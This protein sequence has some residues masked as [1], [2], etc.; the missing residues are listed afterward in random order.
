[1]QF[2]F[3][4]AAPRVSDSVL[5][6]IDTQVELSFNL[7]QRYLNGRHLVENSLFNKMKKV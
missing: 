6:S 4:S 7:S 5:V 2:A 1:M 3:L